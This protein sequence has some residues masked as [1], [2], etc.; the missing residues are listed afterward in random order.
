MAVR[1]KQNKVDLHSLD[2][3][4]N[5]KNTSSKFF[6]VSGVPEEFPIGKSFFK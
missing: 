3:L 6:N 2:V 1:K 4:I 5:D